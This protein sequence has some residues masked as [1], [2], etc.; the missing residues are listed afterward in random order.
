MQKVKYKRL[1]FERVEVKIKQTVV[2]PIVTWTTIKSDG[3]Q[4]RKIEEK[5]SISE[6]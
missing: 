6:I 2:R 4:I 5:P 3:Q 1:K